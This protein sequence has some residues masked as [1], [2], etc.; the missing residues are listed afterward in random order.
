MGCLLKLA[1][2]Y[3]SY[4]GTAEQAAMPT[5]AKAAW[6][7][8]FMHWKFKE[9]LTS[10]SKSSSVEE[11]NPIAHVGG[12]KG[13]ALPYNIPPWKHLAKY[14]PNLFRDLSAKLQATKTV[15]SA[16]PNL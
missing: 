4:H 5:V 8:T 1:I 15:E 6:L 10:Q 16:E 12:G 7:L 9:A 3:L 11:K 14:H 13:Q 2:E